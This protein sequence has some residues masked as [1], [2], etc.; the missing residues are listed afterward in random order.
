MSVMKLTS[1][2]VG[3]IINDHH[4]VYVYQLLCEWAQHLGWDGDMPDMSDVDDM[5]FASDAALEWVND[6][7]TEGVRVDWYEGSIMVFAEHRCDRCGDVVSD[8]YPEWEFVYRFTLDA[9]ENS[10]VVVCHPCLEGWETNVIGFLV[11]EGFDSL[12]EWGWDS[13]YARYADGMWRDETGAMV[14]LLGMLLGAMESAG[15]GN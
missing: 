3:T 10:D 7:M 14:D 12:P 1:A 2:D 5:V 8:G 13:N 9:S 11:S 4:G 15:E 6:H